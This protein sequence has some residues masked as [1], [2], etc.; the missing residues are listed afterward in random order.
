MDHNKILKIVKN[1]IVNLIIFVLSVIAIIAVWMFVQIN[2][3]GKEYADIFGYS[4]FSTET[5][6]MA[7][8]IEKGDIVI[9]KLNE[10]ELNEK[11]IITYKKDKAIITH[12]IIKIDGDSIIAKGDN[13]N[14]EDDPIKKDDVIGK[15][16]IFIN[17]VE[18]WQK[19]FSDI[20]VIIP[21]LI[22]VILFIILISYEQKRDT[23]QINSER[24]KK[25][26]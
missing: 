5:R 3:Q 2:V 23:I 18:I 25:D 16:V 6:S 20:N 12:R 17:N 7:T 8:T 24:N 13:N 10:K 1:I 19:V 11:D 4:I 15:V 21:I 9:V 14:A 26:E 22:T